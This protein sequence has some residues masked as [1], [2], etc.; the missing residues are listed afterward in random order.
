MEEMGEGNRANG[1]VPAVEWPA[2]IKGERTWQDRAN[3]G[4]AQAL[5]WKDFVG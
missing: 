3:E 1:E 4:G 5:A 2:R